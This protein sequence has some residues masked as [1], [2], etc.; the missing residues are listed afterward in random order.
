MDKAKMDQSV[1]K[2][3]Y[4]VCNPGIEYTYSSPYFFP[5]LQ[6]CLK[7]TCK[8]LVIDILNGWHYRQAITHLQSRSHHIN[9]ER[10]MVRQRLVNIC[11]R[12]LLSS[13]YLITFKMPFKFNFLEISFVD[14]FIRSAWHAISV[15][16]SFT[17]NTTRLVLCLYC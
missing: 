9:I 1:K 12:R 5:Y 15:C 6:F 14:Y 2:L 8:S 10:K 3:V 7:L 16:V 13:L 17:R 4:R 11:N